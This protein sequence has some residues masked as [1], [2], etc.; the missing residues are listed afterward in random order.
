V[1]ADA[2]LIELEQPVTLTFALK[3]LNTFIKA[4]PLSPIVI[5]SLEEVGAQRL[6]E[7][8]HMPRV[9]PSLGAHGLPGLCRV[10]SVHCLAFKEGLGCRLF[11][12]AL[13]TTKRRP[14]GSSTASRA[15]LP[16]SPQAPIGP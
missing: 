9:Q 1:Q 16:S 11:S 10:H 13:L 2:T 7:D 4:T 12:K 3:Y 5:L 8:Q 15:S 6:V 14:V